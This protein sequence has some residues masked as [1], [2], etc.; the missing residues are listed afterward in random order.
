MFSF[1]LSLKNYYEQ[2]K[3]SAHEKTI[4]R[5]LL[6]KEIIPENKENQIPEIEIEIF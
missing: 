2:F 4:R 6:Y 5:L 1:N 3:D